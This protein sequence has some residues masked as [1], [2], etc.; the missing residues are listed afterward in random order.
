MLG[1]RTKFRGIFTE[2]MVLRAYDYYSRRQMSPINVCGILFRPKMLYSSY[3]YTKPFACC[4]CCVIKQGPLCRQQSRLTA[5]QFHLLWTVTYATP[6]LMTAMALVVSTATGSGKSA[7]A[8]QVSWTFKFHKVVRQQNSGAVED[9]ILPYSAVYLRIQKWKNYW[10]R[11]AFAIVI[12]KIKVA[13]FL[14][15]AVYISFISRIIA[16]FLIFLNFRLKGDKGRSGVNLSDTVKLHDL[17][18]KAPCLMQD[19]WLCLSY[20]IVDYSYISYYYY[21]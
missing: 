14:W 3:F 4:F 8:R 18:L 10:N 17:N 12:V 15:P 5:V 13:T 19:T 21:Y 9:F 2:G 16:N 20:K 7:S 1:Y 11:S 6:A